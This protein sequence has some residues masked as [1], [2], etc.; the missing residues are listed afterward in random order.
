MICCG[1]EMKRIGLSED[2][3]PLPVYECLICGREH[4]PKGNTPLATS[5]EADLVT[6]FTRNQLAHGHGYAY[7]D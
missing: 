5:S 4:T 1:I 2:E 6:V 7:I 3:E